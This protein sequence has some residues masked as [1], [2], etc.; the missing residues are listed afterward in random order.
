MLCCEGGG[1]QPLVRRLQSLLHIQTVPYLPFD[2]KS[3]SYIEM[4][5]LFSQKLIPICSGFIYNCQK[6]E[7]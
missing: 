5:T 6:L 7:A 1:V 3:Q 4:K 2:H